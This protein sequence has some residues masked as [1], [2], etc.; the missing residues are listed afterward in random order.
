MC[1]RIEGYSEFVGPESGWFWK[2]FIRVGHGK[3]GFWI[4]L[5]AR[6]EGN[7]ARPNPRR[8]APSEIRDFDVCFLPSG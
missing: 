8:V 3:S 1:G 4:F 2:T 7:H 5:G 6:S